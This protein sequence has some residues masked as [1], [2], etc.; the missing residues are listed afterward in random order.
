[1][2][3]FGTALRGSF[4]EFRKKSLLMTLSKTVMM[5]DRSDTTSANFQMSLQH[6]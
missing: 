2:L 5:I 4:W 3:W 6:A 1:M